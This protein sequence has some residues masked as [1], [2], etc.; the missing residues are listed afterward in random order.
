MRNTVHKV[1][2][3][4]DF[5]K[6]EKW[7]S[8]M[9]AKGLCLVSVGFCKYEF[10][11]CEPGEYKICLQLLDN[12]P[13]H[14]ESRKYMEFLESTGAEHVG[15]VLKWVYFRKKSADGA[16]SLFSDNNSRLRY[17]SRVISFLTAI[18][19]LNLVIGVHNLAIALALGSP[20]NYLGLM[21][22]ALGIW[23]TIGTL[24]LVKRHRKMKQDSRIFE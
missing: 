17:L 6:E 19:V 22:M 20:L 3:A 8:E 24:R 1:F 14:P 18:T 11:D 9:A 5:E 16:F 13:T 23:G 12:A 7:L 15:S 21:N 2:F 4:W 10:E